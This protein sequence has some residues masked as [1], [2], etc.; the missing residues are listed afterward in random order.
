ML[1]EKPWLDPTQMGRAKVLVEVKLDKPFPQRV[2]LV[3][4][5][6]AITMVD[7]LYSWLPTVCSDCGHLGHKAS[8]CLL[9]TSSPVVHKKTPKEATSSVLPPVTEIAGAGTAKA[10]ENPETIPSVEKSTPVS[11]TLIPPNDATPTSTPA[12]SN[13]SSFHKILS[14]PQGTSSSPVINPV[15][16]STKEASASKQASLSFVASASKQASISPVQPEHSIRRTLSSASLRNNR[17]ASLDSSED[18][19]ED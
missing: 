1:T 17:F 9:R 16:A 8:R 18:E 6:D 2:A 4:I 10:L 13:I 19:Y 14:Y 3:D 15:M 7:V 12:T 5:S 11:L